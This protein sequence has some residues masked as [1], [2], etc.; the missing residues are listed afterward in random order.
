ME[1]IQQSLLH[2]IMEL[3]KKKKKTNKQTAMADNMLK[4][5]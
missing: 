4:M 5:V 1:P 3:W 2:F